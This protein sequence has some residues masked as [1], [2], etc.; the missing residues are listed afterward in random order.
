MPTAATRAARTQ[1]I[2]VA[3]PTGPVP[4]EVKA[5]SSG[6]AV[7]GTNAPPAAQAQAKPAAPAK[8]ATPA[9]PKVEKAPEGLP[10][11]P[12][13]GGKV[14][15]KDAT[16]VVAIRE[17]VGTIKAPAIR[18]FTGTPTAALKVGSKFA[19]HHA[20][21]KAPCGEWTVIAVITA[22]SVTGKLPEGTTAL[23]VNTVG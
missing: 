16:G 11:L 1:K 13:K 20:S 15:V 21:N 19:S 14:V 2:T 4:A 22:G 9:K 8:P 3:P 17:L 12:V 7:T 23:A 6:K 18:L 10:I 5:A